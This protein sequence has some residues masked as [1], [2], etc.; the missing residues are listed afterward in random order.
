MSDVLYDLYFHGETLPGAPLET[1]KKNL[2]IVFKSDAAR[3]DALFNGQSHCIRRGADQAAAEKYQAVLQKA[4]AVIELRPQQTTQSAASAAEAAVSA[5][6]KKPS[7]AER[8]AAVAA[9]LD[10]KAAAVAAAA[11]AAAAEREGHYDLS[12]ADRGYLLRD[13]ERQL[14]EVSEPS[15]EAPNLD[16][17]G[18]KPQTAP[19]WI[20]EKPD[21]PA[22]DISGISV[23]ESHDRLSAEAPPPPPAPD[24]DFMSMAEVGSRIGPESTPAAAPDLNLDRLNIA[25]AGADLLQPGERK[26]EAVVSVPDISHLQIDKPS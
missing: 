25:P 22:P 18:S 12:L 6:P 21:V 15:V 4:G 23:A 11:A 20:S 24:T 7:M 9:E 14:N 26:P 5:A 17:V 19:S 10:E 16:L 3:V 8:L 13:K 2:I 1:V